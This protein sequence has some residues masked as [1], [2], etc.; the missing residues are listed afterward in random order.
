MTESLKLSLLNAP[1]PM[2]RIFHGLAVW[3]FASVASQAIAAEDNPS[4]FNRA[5][6]VINTFQVM[7]ALEPPNFDRI[8][9]K[10]ATMRMQLQF[11][12]S[13]P[14]PGNTVT[15]SK[16]WFGTLTDGSFILLLDEMSGA[17]GKSTSCA[18]VADV[19]DRDAFRAEA[20]RT[21]KLP[22]APTPE[23]RDDG[24][25]SYFWDGV[26]GPGTTVLDRDFAPSGKP[27]VMLK[28]LLHE[29]PAL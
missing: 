12:K 24:S 9:Q 4:H 1:R 14:S 29:G 16:S 20:I 18:I 10:A 5:Q 6:S 11:N 15:R 28:L 25:R 22:D 26:W 2:C 13:G 17:K 21:M 19:P 7:C 3:V 27:G 8:D 23:L